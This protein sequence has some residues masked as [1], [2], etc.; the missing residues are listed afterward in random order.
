MG[1]ASF[2]S[3]FSEATDANYRAWVGAHLNGLIA[4]GWVQTA[5]T[6]QVTPAT[7]STLVKPTAI[8]VAGACY[9]VFQFADPL[10]SAYPLFVKLYFGTNAV[11]QDYPVMFV[12]IGKG[13]DGAGGLTDTLLPITPLGATSSATAVTTDAPCI[14]GAGEGWLAMLG[15][16]GVRGGSYRQFVHLV[17]ER[18]RDASGNPTGSGVAVILPDATT[19]IFTATSPTSGGLLR[20]V[21]INYNT[22]AQNIGAIPV[23]LPGTVNGV[24]LGP[25]TSLAAGG[26]GPVF[27]IVYLAPAVAPWQSMAVVA[28][29]QGDMPGDVFETT[30]LGHTVRMMPCPSSSW[31]QWGVA[32]TSLSVP[33]VSNYIGCG[34]R[35]DE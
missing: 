31:N 2:T 23:M 26:I 3:I 17:V 34:L 13:S 8:G 20:L 15:G 16:L 21:A 28:I 18:S 12:Q 6:G 7:V 5:D 25:G 1:H 33:V 22:G 24:V 14:S 29:P 35:W 27:P 32:Y 10:Q 11:T 30:L 4:G 19:G 9:A